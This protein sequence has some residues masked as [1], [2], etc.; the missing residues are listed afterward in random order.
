MPVT[1]NKDIC[2]GKPCVQKRRLW[3]GLVVSN[4]RETGLDEFA[5]DYDLP[6]KSIREAIEYCAS[7]KC[8]NNCVMYCQECKKRSSEGKEIWKIAQ[9]LKRKYSINC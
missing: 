6:K 3:V 2:S 8:V 4:V 7:E 1:S 5:V 9:E